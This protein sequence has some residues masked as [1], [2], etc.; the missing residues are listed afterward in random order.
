MTQWLFQGGRIGERG[1]W[2]RVRPALSLSGP[3]AGEG[4]WLDGRAIPGG[5]SLRK[6]MKKE[7][8]RRLLG[9]GMAY[10]A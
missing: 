4:S 8:Q 1:R 2:I 9:G 7:P 6:P 10:Q 3:V 5:M